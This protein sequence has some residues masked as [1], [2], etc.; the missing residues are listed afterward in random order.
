MSNLI[1]H[2]PEALK[3][4][5]NNDIYHIPEGELVKETILHNNA[6]A[7]TEPK[8]FAYLGENN[9]Y[10]LVLIDDKTNKEL[11]TLHLDVLLKIMT[12][13][14]LELRDLAI[15]NLNN[16]PGVTFSDLKDFFVCSKLVLLGISP[17]RISLPA[18][19]SNQPEEYENVKVLATYSLEEM[20]NSRD[21]KIQFWDV[22]KPF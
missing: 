16:Y 10:F 6:L 19:S 14:G 22:M 18:L 1:T 12:A 21:K 9:K 3:L 5:F 8:T 15:L 4:L 13:K 20:I 11:N 7:D 17:E 2:H